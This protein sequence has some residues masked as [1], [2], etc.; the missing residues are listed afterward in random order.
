MT[1]DLDRFRKVLGLLGSDHDGERSAAALRA[2][3]M[4]K[5]AGMGW[6]DVSANQ[7]AQKATGGGG[8]NVLMRTL[9]QLNAYKQALTTEQI[10]VRML[11]A[12]MNTLRQQMYAMSEPKAEDIAPAE[13]VEQ[14]PKTKRKRWSMFARIDG[15]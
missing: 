4:L 11:E 6:A 2:T 9:D 7:A 1:L 14:T 12:E 3:A 8:L 10:R 15:H 5:E 13:V